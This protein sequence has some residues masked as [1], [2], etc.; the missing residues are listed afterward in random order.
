M[1]R[2]LNLALIL[3]ILLSCAAM[4]QD[5]T[6]NAKLD[7]L[8]YYQNK[9]L[10]MQKR[11]FSEVVQYK[12]PLAGKKYG[13]E[14]NPAFLLGSLSQSY[15][16]LSGGFSMFDINRSAEIAFPFY[17]QSGKAGDQ[18]NNS[19]LIQY[20]QD[21]LYRKFLGQHQDG[22]FIE[23]GV[24]YTHINEDYS[25]FH[26]SWSP[27]GY[28]YSVSQATRS[29]NKVGGMF[30]IGYRYFSYSGLYWGTSLKFGA[31][32]SSDEESFDGVWLYPG[33]TIIDVELL[34]FGVAF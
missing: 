20:N 21:V 2:K 10:E 18:S 32:L 9:V 22:F 30:G 14:F 23:G 27:A 4:A 1:T 3:T 25:N 5:T 29:S 12:E 8:L 34:K 11:I 28:Y 19:K 31:Y 15:L 7:S 16:V 33:K 17:F 6:M 26:Y 13:I 24:R